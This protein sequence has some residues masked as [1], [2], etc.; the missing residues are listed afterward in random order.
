MVSIKHGTD[1][2]NADL[3][4]TTIAEVKEQYSVIWNIDP[5]AASLVNGK[6]VSGET[7]LNDFDKVEFIKSEKKYACDKG[8]DD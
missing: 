2:E 5:E 8:K 7:V 6:Q 3:A 1:E 4:G